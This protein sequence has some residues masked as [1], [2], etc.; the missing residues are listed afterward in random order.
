MFTPLNRNAS[1]ERKIKKYLT[2]SYYTGYELNPYFTEN[3]Q[4]MMFEQLLKC[5]EE[6]KQEWESGSYCKP[7]VPNE[8]MFLSPYVTKQSNVKKIFRKCFPYKFNNKLTKGAKNLLK[9]YMIRYSQSGSYKEKEQRM[10][11]IFC[12]IFERLHERREQ[13]INKVEDKVPYEL[14]REIRGFI[15][16]SPSGGKKSKRQIKRKIIINDKTKKRKYKNKSIKNRK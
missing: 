16:P 2:E 8:T 14:A 4:I 10:K 9:A 5:D 12:G 1:L 13:Y 15:G 6:F 3:N 11:Q 7:E